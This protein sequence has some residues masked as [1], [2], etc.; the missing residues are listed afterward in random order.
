MK[1][2]ELIEILNQFDENMRVMI[3][4]DEGL[5][6]IVLVREYEEEEKVIEIS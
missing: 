2:K 5:E 3:S 6:D 4:V 1:V